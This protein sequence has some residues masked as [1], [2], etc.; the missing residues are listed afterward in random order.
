MNNRTWFRGAAAL[1]MT[2]VSLS[3][4]VAAPPAPNPCAASHKGLFY[5]NDFS[6]LDSPQYDG[7]CLGDSFKQLPVGDFGTVDFGG[8]FRERYHHEVGMGQSG[9]LSRF[10]DTTTNFWLTRLRTYMNWQV[11][12]CLRF[13]CEG[14]YAD[15][16]TDD[17]N[18]IPR[19]ID[20]NY[21]DILNLFVDVALLDGLTAR[22]GRQE[23]L[24]GNQRVVSP[25]DWANTRRTFEGAR[26]LYKGDEWATDVFYTNFVPVDVDDL[27]EADYDQTFYG[28]YS[29]YAGFQNF[30]VD[31]YYLGYDN[32][33]TGPANG[34]QD[35]SLHTLGLRINGSLDNWLFELEGGP[36]FGRQSGLGVDHSAWFGTAGLGRS[37]TK[38]PWS[39][40]LWCYYD[41]ASGNSG[42]GDWNRFNQ[43][44]PLAH[45]YFGFIDAV[46]RSNVESPNVLLTMKP[47]PK[48]TILL[49]Y[50]HFMA[51]EAGDIVPA[52]GGTPTQA[53][54]SDHL[55]DE[56]DL[57]VQY[58]LSPRS[59]ILFGYSHFW[60]GD[61][62]AGSPQDADFFYSQY[63]LNF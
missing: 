62:L 17:G 25:L 23:L 8:E 5:L 54:A 60:R 12:D 51:A 47:S 57:I 19:G 50:W 56:L 40:T 37:M 11:S 42:G 7:S 58:G 53:V 48:T 39:P 43:L 13:Y 52:I 24:Y 49:W 22:V 10:Q 14:I 2:A 3:A 28:F 6:Y 55:G 35:F 45:K 41:Y 32:E 63:T 61:R 33:N 4:A 30:T 9:G 16:S 38:L 18:Y 34:N 59:N 46:Q 26:L 29:T 15:A 31:A 44:F 20:R 1:A 36:Q 21:G 27:D